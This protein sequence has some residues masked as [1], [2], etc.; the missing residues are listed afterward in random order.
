MG[1]GTRLDQ[2]VRAESLEGQRGLG[3]RAAAGQGLAQQTE[4]E[5]TGGE[6]PVEQAQFAEGGD[7]WAVDVARFALLGEGRNCCSARARSSSHQAVCDGSSENA[8]IPAPLLDRIA[9]Y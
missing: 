6:Q 1:R 7:E 3:L 4:V 2:R 9:K 8:D 5:G